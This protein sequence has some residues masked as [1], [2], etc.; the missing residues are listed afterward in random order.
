MKAPLAALFALLFG[1]AA[2]PSPAWKMPALPKAA[3]APS[4]A[5]SAGADVGESVDER[6]DLPEAGAHPARH[7]MWL[8]DETNAWAEAKKQN[9]LLLIDFS[10]EWC[11][12]CM[13]LEADT[14]SDESVQT[15]IAH[16][17]VPLRVDVTEDSHVNREQLKR[18]HIR[19]LPAVLLIDPSGRE[20]DRLDHYVNVDTFLSRLAAARQK[21]DQPERA[22]AR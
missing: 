15:A 6:G 2:S 17:F 8:E 21:I 5:P 4:W 20:L 18:Y 3:P 10:A 1:C 19:G 9:R 11:T 12:P 13:L 7:G 16:D 14:F 22:A